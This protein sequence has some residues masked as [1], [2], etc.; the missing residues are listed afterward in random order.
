MLIWRSASA[1]DGTKEPW[2]DIKSCANAEAEDA[3]STTLSE[4][5]RIRYAHVDD[6]L[7]NTKSC[8]LRGAIKHGRRAA[9]RGVGGPSFYAAAQS[10]PTPRNRAK[11]KRPMLRVQSYIKFSMS[12]DGA[13]RNAAG[14]F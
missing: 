13:N 3:T 1:T 10:F 12:F 9:L 7:Y 8:V 4:T 2:E 14:V 11:P 6:E 5:T